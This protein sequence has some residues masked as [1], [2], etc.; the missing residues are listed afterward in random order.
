MAIYDRCVLT[1]LLLLLL[2]LSDL[3]WVMMTDVVL[4]HMHLFVRTIDQ[5]SAT[6]A[7]PEEKRYDMFLLYIKKVRLRDAV[8]CRSVG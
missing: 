8:C 1:W 3:A 7:V 2:L 4:T 5:N 6:Q